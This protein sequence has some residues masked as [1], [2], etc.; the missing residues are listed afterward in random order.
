MR[1]ISSIWSCL[2]IEFT[3]YVFCSAD[4]PTVCLTHE[5]F[6]TRYLFTSTEGMN[7]IRED[8][9]NICTRWPDA[10]DDTLLKLFLKVM[11]SSITAFNRTRQDR[12]PPQHVLL[13]FRSIERR[14]ENEN[15][16]LE[17]V[18][19]KYTIDKSKKED[20]AAVIRSS[21]PEAVKATI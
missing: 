18:R 8:V 19:E 3:A 14:Y 9:A 6:L 15:A 10:A 2:S 11:K 17:Q 13:N 12:D 1:Y 16:R 7:Q 4:F 5:A 20:T 21:I